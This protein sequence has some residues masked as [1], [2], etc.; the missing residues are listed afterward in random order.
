[1]QWGC[2]GVALKLHWICIGLSL[3]LHVIAFL[4]FDVALK[5]QW[6][7]LGIALA[8]Y[9]LCLGLAVGGGG[10]AL[11]LPVLCRGIAVALHWIGIEVA[12]VRHCC[13]LFICFALGWHW[14][15]IRLTLGWS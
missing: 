2:I 6:L 12:L 1:M 7:G 5:W 11:A 4:V 10:L 13:L 8:L 15:C 3:Y 9:W 14:I